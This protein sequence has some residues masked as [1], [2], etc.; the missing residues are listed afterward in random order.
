MA[1][2]EPECRRI[3]EYYA[4]MDAWKRPGNAFRRR[5]VPLE[6]CTIIPGLPDDIP[7]WSPAC[8]TAIFEE[9]ATMLPSWSP[10]IPYEH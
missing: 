2:S 1:H 10:D 7:V 9:S 5:E 8:F 3:R 4:A 6:S